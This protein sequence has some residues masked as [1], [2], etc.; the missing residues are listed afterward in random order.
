M[1][2][3][4]ERPAQDSEQHACFYMAWRDCNNYKDMCDVQIQALR[5]DSIRCDTI[6]HDDTLYDTMCHMTVLDGM[7]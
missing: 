7:R 1:Q 2:L 3:T 6:R 4:Y 5:C